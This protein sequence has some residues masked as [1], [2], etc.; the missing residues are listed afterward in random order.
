MIGGKWPPLKATINPKIGARGHAFV[1]GGVGR[2]HYVSE[3]EGGGFIGSLALHGLVLAVVALSSEYQAPQQNIRVVAVNLVRFGDK[4][5]SPP[6]LLT[7]PIPQDKASA[8]PLVQLAQIALA[9]IVAPQ[10]QTPTPTRPSAPY[11]GAPL[12]TAAGT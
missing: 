11:P 2:R 5:T 10:P 3:V 1:T 12:K 9:P 4:S 8:V 6:S 7:T